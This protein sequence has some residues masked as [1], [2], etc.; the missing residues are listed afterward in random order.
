MIAVLPVLLVVG[1]V[2]CV[3]GLTNDPPLGLLAFPG[4]VVLV[5]AVEWWWVRREAR[6]AERRRRGRGGYLR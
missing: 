6:L 4:I 1:V 5:V 3:V 2:L